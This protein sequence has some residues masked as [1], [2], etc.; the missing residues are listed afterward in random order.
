MLLLKFKCSA[1]VFR[2]P[3]T[4][5]LW[6]SFL[7]KVWAGFV[8]NSSHLNSSRVFS[9][10]L[11][12]SP[13]ELHSP[14]QIRLFGVSFSICLNGFWAPF[15]SKFG[16]QFFCLIR[17]EAKLFRFLFLKSAWPS[18]S[19]SSSTVRCQFFN[20]LLQSLFGFYFC[21]N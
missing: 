6:T 19:C 9:T 1:S 11:L 3:W 17:I 10:S 7:S 2:F 13:F 16:F 5:S 15:L 14:V 18:C 12:K 4:E 8:F 21:P 20:F